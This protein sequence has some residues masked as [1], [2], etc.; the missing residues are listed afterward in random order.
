MIRALK[1]LDTEGS[2]FSIIKAIYNKCTANIILDGENKVF[3]LRSRTRQGSP[4]P[5]LPFNIVTEILTI[6]IGQ[7]KER[8]TKR[9]GIL[10]LEGCWGGNSGPCTKRK[11]RSQIILFCR[12][13]DPV[14]RTF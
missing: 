5:P 4:L 14:F 2:Y 3:P 1:K 10:G 11:G 8:D 6:A 9:K 13:H 12:G 7:E